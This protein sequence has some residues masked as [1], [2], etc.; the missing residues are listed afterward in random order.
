MVDEEV[1]LVGVEAVGYGFDIDKYA[2]IMIKGSIGIVDGMKIYVVFKEDGELV[3]VYFILVGLDYLGVGL[4]YVYFKDLG[5]VEYVAV[6]DE[7]VV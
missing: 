3:L 4:E 1:K 6:I 5:C 7:E 2:V